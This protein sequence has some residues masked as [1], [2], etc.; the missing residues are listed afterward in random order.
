MP[1]RAAT[2]ARTGGRAGTDR[3]EG[4]LGQAGLVVRVRGRFVQQGLGGARGGQLVVGL[5][6]GGWHE[7]LGQARGLGVVV[8]RVLVVL[9]VAVGVLAE[10]RRLA[11]AV[12]VDAALVVRMAGGRG[13]KKGGRVGEGRERGREE[14]R[15]RGREEGR[16]GGKEGGREGARKGGRKGG[17]ASG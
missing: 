14:A 6:R 3:E 8:V 13:E 7:E 15:E 12:P 4:L 10:H 9:Q 2:G 16:E 5:D 1:D 17:T 11:A